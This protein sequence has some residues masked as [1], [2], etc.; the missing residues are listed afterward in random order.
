MTVEGIYRACGSSD[1]IDALRERFEA[2]WE[3][4]DGYLRSVEDVHVITG[5]L[6]LYLRLLPLPLI[7]F[8]AYPMYIEAISKERWKV[9]KSTTTANYPSNHYRKVEPGP[10]AV[11]AARCHSQAAARPLP[12]AQVPGDPSPSVN[13]SPPNSITAQLVLTLFALFSSVSSQEHRNLM[14]AKNLSLI[15][16]QT[17]LYTPNIPMMFQYN[18]W[19]LEAKVV[20]TLIACHSKIFIK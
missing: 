3:Q 19:E 14:S 18:C 8:E 20:E 15:F 1:A 13:T 16:G 7:T 4:A 9:G 5:L 11:G 17:L 10:V 2:H 6:K 12:D